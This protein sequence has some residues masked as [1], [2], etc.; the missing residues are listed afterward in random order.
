[1]IRALLLALLLPLGAAAA[2]RVAIA[3]GDLTEIAF[4]LGAG[5][6]VIAVDT[7]STYPEAATALPQLG[8][9]RRLAAEGVLSVAPDLLLVS[10]G[11]G[12][13]AALA[14]IEAAGVAVARAPDIEGPEGIG[15]KIRFVG[16][17][18][19]RGAEA[20]RLAAAVEADLAAVA[21]R[22]ARLAA[23]P[24]VLFILAFQNGLPLVGGEGTSAD[25][26]IRL[27]GAEN[28]AAGAEG[29]KPMSREALI[30]AAPEAILMMTGRAHAT[31]GMAA[32]LALP[33]LS[34]TPAGRAGRG[35]EMD[36]NLLLN[37][38]PRTAEAAARLARLVHGAAAE[39]AGL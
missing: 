7:T 4:A 6:Q 21:A 25:A 23:R 30:A 34:A 28:A 16:A 15:P 39:A 27:A 14:Q 18:L 10:P 20:E 3:G 31:D 38:G 29:W 35:F 32:T 37:F 22:V 9:F 24:R 12:P 11:A 13:S 33:E 26:I 1:M 17:A 5:D 8:Y 19:G 36:G 2:E